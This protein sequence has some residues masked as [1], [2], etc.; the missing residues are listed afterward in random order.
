MLNLIRRAGPVDL[1]SARTPG[2]NTWTEFIAEAEASKRAKRTTRPFDADWYL[3]RDVAGSTVVAVDGRLLEL[4]D[5]RALT[6]AEAW[7]QL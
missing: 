4:A 1:T 5:G 2:Y 6:M 7:K 3:G